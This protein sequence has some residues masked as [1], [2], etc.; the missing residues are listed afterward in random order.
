MS[1]SFYIMRKTDRRFVRTEKTIYQA[2]VKLLQESD[3]ESLTIEDLIFEADIN[4]STFYLHYQSLDQ[5][6]SALEDDL[7]SSIS[8]TLYSLENP[9]TI[10]DFFSSIMKYCSANKELAKAVLKASTYRFNEK[11]ENLFK[12]YLKPLKPVKRNKITD[13]NTFLITS[14]IQAEVGVFRMWVLDNCRF[15]K[16]SVLSNCIRIAQSSVYEGLFTK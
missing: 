7:I 8:T 15:N 14:L 2:M 9:H 6:V 5:L 13:E 1:Y 10:E 3:P 4:K 12:K 16:D 11:I